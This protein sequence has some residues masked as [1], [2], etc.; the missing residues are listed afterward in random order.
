MVQVGP[1]SCIWK[2]N[3]MSVQCEQFGKNCV[4][5]D[6]EYNLPLSMDKRQNK[7]A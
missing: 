6:T 3:G 2:F 7:E 4:R 1:T 5:K